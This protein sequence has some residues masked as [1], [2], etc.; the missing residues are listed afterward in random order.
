[1]I[2]PVLLTSSFICLLVLFCMA[3]SFDLE[4]SKERGKKLYLAQCTTCHLKNGEG[5]NGVFP[6]VARANNLADKNKLVKILLKG[7]RGLIKVNGIEYNGAMTGYP[8]TNEQAADMIN[9]LRN[10]WGNTGKTILP[11]EIQ[12]ALKAPVKGYEAF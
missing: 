6:P 11:S 7:Q 8:L 5:L 1:M 3:Q 12:T 4:A 9:Y 2:K 10:S